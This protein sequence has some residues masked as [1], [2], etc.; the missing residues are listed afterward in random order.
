MLL[1]IDIGNSKI[2]CALFVEDE[3]VNTSASRNFSEIISFIKKNEFDD[4]AIC[5]VVPHKLKRLQK[6][7]KKKQGLN[8]FI[9]NKDSAFNLR[10]NYKSPETLGMD[11]ICS[12]EGAYFFQK[13]KGF[14]ENQIILSIDFGTA[15]TINII[16][17]PNTFAG[18]LIAPGVGT[19]FKS[20]HNKTAQLPKVNFPDYKSFVGY[21]TVSSIASGVTNSVIGLIERTQNYFSNEEKIEEQFV[22]ITG[23]FAKPVMPLLKG[24]IFL[25]DSLVLKGIN[26]IYK[27]N[28]T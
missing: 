19:M 6:F 14:K 15:T 16:R 10:L 21:D 24:K 23:G 9:I 12:A 11:R 17:F 20:L 2:K 8:P 18:G 13:Q 5:S 1:A 28:K 26:Q 3:I 7:L 25:D 4:I 22:Y 27:K